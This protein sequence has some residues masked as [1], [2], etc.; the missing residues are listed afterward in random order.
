MAPPRVERGNFDYES[1]MAAGRRLFAQ[2][3]KPDGIFCANDMM[4]MGVMDVARSEF[5][6]RIPEDLGIVGFDDIPQA[7][8]ATYDLTTFRQDVD[9]MTDETLSILKARIENE[10]LEPKLSLIA[11]RLVSRKSVRTG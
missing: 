2:E 7:A 5:K 3:E 9:A 10:N 1:G 11:G 8:W 4:A 6:L